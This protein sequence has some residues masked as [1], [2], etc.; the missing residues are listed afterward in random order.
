MTRI[1][2]K[3]WRASSLP[4]TNVP[5]I[6]IGL[7]STNNK[8][9][10]I[11]PLPNDVKEQGEKRIDGTENAVK[12][13]PPQGRSLEM[14]R[15]A[16]V[17]TVRPTTKEPKAFTAS[18][19]RRSKSKSPETTARNQQKWSGAVRAQ[20]KEL[21]R[22]LKGNE[23]VS[24]MIKHF[25]DP[26]VF[27]LRWAS[28]TVQARASLGVVSSSAHL[29][30]DEAAS[31]A[32]KS[33]VPENSNTNAHSS[34]KLSTSKTRRLEATLAAATRTMA[35]SPEE[36]LHN[37]DSPSLA[38]SEVGTEDDSSLGFGGEELHTQ[39]LHLAKKT[40]KRELYD[41]SFENLERKA[42]NRQMH[43]ES[44]NS[45]GQNSFAG[46]DSTSPVPFKQRIVLD[47]AHM[48]HLST[49][50]HRQ[51]SH[52]INSLQELVKKAR[53]EIAAT[54]KRKQSRKERMLRE[55]LETSQNWDRIHLDEHDAETIDLSSQ[56]PHKPPKLT[57]DEIADIV[58][59]I[60]Q[61]EE[62]SK[63]VRWDLIN[64]IVGIEEEEDDD[65][66]DRE[67]T[68][69]NRLFQSTLP[70]P[71][72][73]GPDNE[74]MTKP[75]NT[76][77]VGSSKLP[78]SSKGGERAQKSRHDEGPN[79][80][81]RQLIRQDHGG[82]AAEKFQRQYGLTAEEMEDVIAH[83]SLCEE[84]NTEVRWDLINRIICPDQDDY[85]SPLYATALVR[86][87][88]RRLIKHS[89]DMDES[90]SSGWFS[91]YPEFDDC[92]S[93]VTFSNEQDD[94]VPMAGTKKKKKTIIKKGG[95]FSRDSLN[96]KS[97][98][99]LSPTEDSGKPRGLSDRHGSGLGLGDRLGPGWLPSWSDLGSP[100]GA[101]A[102][103][104]QPDSVLRKRVSELQ[105]FNAAQ[106]DQAREDAKMVSLS[107][108]RHP[109]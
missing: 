82:T 46:F 88:T 12:E 96:Q 50:V 4:A 98:T 55:M 107:S 28:A 103:D 69:H 1:N 58:K 18:E 73:G 54:E 10:E 109:S 83:L 11:A 29:L 92:V 56:S 84:T 71:K 85:V 39:L 59:H 36:L 97:S 32:D 3:L 100:T 104:T 77:Q 80:A 94:V 26:D 49:P 93:E 101:T 57:M 102:M 65:A 74:T 45:M 25:S 51:H 44:L 89:D 40:S 17:P 106:R 62:N 53:G 90:S 95:K 41:G 87:S 2:S 43:E 15:R 99:F 20:D 33:L 52:V 91:I 37:L 23:K 64:D 63:P 47:L 6:E 105:A 35:E 81:E 34:A 75:D 19:S 48:E 30:D 86:P 14:S 66:D 7:P 13:E 24:T 60:N 38:T 72:L 108:Q 27:E 42:S 31:W 9:M 68:G 16:S 8:L 5:Q 70:I 79:E 67:I 61:C 21:F 76:G 78:W 22:G